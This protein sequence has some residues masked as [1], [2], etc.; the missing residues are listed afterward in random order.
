MLGTVIF[1]IP[2]PGI[3]FAHPLSYAFLHEG[4]TIRLLIRARDPSPPEKVSK[5]L[6]G[7]CA[8]LKKDTSY[9]QVVEVTGLE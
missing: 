8:M 6:V 1:S 9:R 7:V 3:E 5:R 2:L 4:I